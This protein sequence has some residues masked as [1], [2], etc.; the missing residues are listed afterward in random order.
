MDRRL[1]RENRY[2]DLSEIGK[3]LIDNL[4]GNKEEYLES[5]EHPMERYIIAYDQN[6]D[7]ESTLRSIAQNLN[8]QLDQD[9]FREELYE[10]FENFSNQ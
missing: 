3:S 8:I 7:D 2:E 6:L 10:F 9:D 4:Y 1:L 5:F